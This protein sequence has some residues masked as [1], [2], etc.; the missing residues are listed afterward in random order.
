MQA[1]GKMQATDFRLFMYRVITIFG[2]QLVNRI[3]HANRTKI[4]HSSYSGRQTGWPV[5]GLASMMETVTRF[6]WK[7]CSLQFTL[8]LHFTTG[9]Q[10]AG[11]YKTWTSGPW[12]PSMD[13]VHQNMDRVHIHVPLSLSQGSPELHRLTIGSFY[14]TS[15]KF[16]LQN[17]WYPWDFAFMI[18]KSCENYYSD[19]FSLQM[20]FW[21]CDKLVLNLFIWRA[22][23]LF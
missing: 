22:R 11:E 21:F 19:R 14:I 1:E 16:K 15:L 17:Y 2:C 3:I 20:R 6:S 10:S 12:T 9:Q 23:E 8:G 13:Q 5:Y 18:L 4:S 7:V